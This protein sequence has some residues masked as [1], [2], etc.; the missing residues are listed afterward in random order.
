MRE[1]HSRTRWNREQGS[2]DQ[3]QWQPKHLLFIP[4]FCLLS[5][6]KE[7]VNRAWVRN[8]TPGRRTEILLSVPNK[9][10]LGQN[11]RMDI[12]KKKK[13]KKWGS[14]SPRLRPEGSGVLYNLPLLNISAFLPIVLITSNLQRN[15]KANW[16][17]VYKVS[18]GVP[19]PVSLHSY[20]VNVVLHSAGHG[21]LRP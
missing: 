4:A 21:D 17:P 2:V 11:A 18:V 14:C 20:L 19:R 5:N 12:W 9:P 7:L 8:L 10:L 15:H 3:S 13:K 16:I 6:R 1:A